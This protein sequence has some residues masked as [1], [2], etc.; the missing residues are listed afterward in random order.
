[1]PSFLPELCYASKPRSAWGFFF[2]LFLLHVY[3]PN[4]V[5]IC[6]KKE[7]DIYRIGEYGLGIWWFLFGHRGSLW[8]K[9]SRDFNWR[10]CGK[11]NCFLT[12]LLVFSLA[13]ALSVVMHNSSMTQTTLSIDVK[14]TNKLGLSCATKD[15]LI[16]DM[17][18]NFC[19]MTNL[20]AP[21]E[22]LH[23]L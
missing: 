11:T 12:N 20:L 22:E 9:R 17:D 18:G 5:G 23:K 13:V 19:R 3:S 14:N 6:I 8:N 1:M 21:S 16:V 4:N 2:P 10:S 7:P 15:S